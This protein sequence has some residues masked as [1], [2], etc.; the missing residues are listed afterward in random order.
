MKNLQN[1]LKS[2][3]QFQAAADFLLKNQKMIKKLEIRFSVAIACHSAIMS[4]D[5]LGEIIVRGGTGSKLEKLKLHRTKC[6]SLITNIV[7]PALHK[8]LC[9]DIAC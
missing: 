8:D 6:A 1:M 5:H 2:Q 7:S 3:V 9:K 4:I